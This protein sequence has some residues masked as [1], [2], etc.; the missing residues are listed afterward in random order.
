MVNVLMDGFNTPETGLLAYLGRLHPKLDFAAASDLGLSVYDALHGLSVASSRWW[1]HAAWGG[2][3]FPV[4]MAAFEAILTLSHPQVGIL[5]PTATSVVEP[6]GDRLVALNA[7]MEERLGPATGGGPEIVREMWDRRL[8]P[9]AMVCHRMGA[10]GLE[11]ASELLDCLRGGRVALAPAM[12]RCLL[13]RYVQA[14]EIDRCTAFLDSI[15][16]QGLMSEGEAA[17]ALVSAH[18]KYGNALR[19]DELWREGRTAGLISPKGLRAAVMDA[20]LDAGHLERVLEILEDMR[21]VGDGLRFGVLVKLVDAL[22]R[23]GNLGLA[24]EIVREAGVEMVASRSMPVFAALVDA[25]TAAELID[26]ADAL[27]AEIRDTKVIRPVHGTLFKVMDARTRTGN[28]DRAD[29]LLA[30][31]HA[32][33]GDVGGRGDIGRLMNAHI[34]AGSLERA[35][36]IMELVLDHVICTHHTKVTAVWI[37]TLMALVDAHREVGHESHADEI[38]AKALE[39]LSRQSHLLFKYYIKAG[40]VD[41]ADRALETMRGMGEEPSDATFRKW[42]TAL[43]KAGNLDRADEELRARLVRP[44]VLLE[45]VLPVKSARSLM[46][47]HIE[48]GNAECVREVLEEMGKA[49]YALEVSMLIYLIR[50]CIKAASLDLACELLAMMTTLAETSGAQDQ[51]LEEASRTLDTALIKVGRLEKVH[52]IVREMLSAHLRNAV[53][54]SGAAILCDRAKFLVSAYVN[55]GAVERADALVAEMVDAGLALQASLLAAQVEIHIAAGDLDL[56]SEALAQMANAG[57]KDVDEDAVGQA[58][59]AL[60]NAFINTGH[61]ARADEVLLAR[62]VDPKLFLKDALLEKLVNSLMVAHIEAGHP[63]CAREVLEEMG[64]AGYAP[65]V[66]LLVHLIR[67]CIGAGSY[68]LACELLEKTT[69]LAETSGA[70]GRALEETSRTLESALIKAGYLE[71]AHELISAR[72][73]VARELNARGDLGDVPA[74]AKPT[75]KV[76]TR[77]MMRLIEAGDLG[78]ASELAVSVVDA[79]LKPQ[80]EPLSHLIRA[81]IKEGALD[82]A[83]RVL[84]L[85]QGVGLEFEKEGAKQA[86]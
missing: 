19:A 32:L 4:V 13:F 23:V 10:Y 1:T 46:V 30:W 9:P 14:G 69:T 42:M 71:K 59:L 55:A 24:E 39:A 16:T 56:A 64:E 70:K 74:A 81:Q 68:D 33:G 51:A 45:G 37:A 25:L 22:I 12:V 28:L 84:A 57:R 44:E 77:L 40:N 80:L 18:A 43:V 67:R 52:E 3:A 15:K 29:D 60:V 5:D 58:T 63:E 53:G 36:E 61:L 2:K 75:L 49:G 20:L 78:R 76:A 38:E 34:K 7:V 48:A 79:G 31:V 41:Q 27:L 72:L 82:D 21:A 17:R 50:V 66:S 62:L 73:A 85:G 11:R 54:D 26:R 47:A 35:E 6:E 86:P 83:A 65:R 8:V